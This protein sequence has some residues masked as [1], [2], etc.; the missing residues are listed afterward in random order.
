[1]DNLD[2]LI[3]LLNSQDLEKQHR[4]KKK[5]EKHAETHP[6]SE[7][8][9]DVQ[10]HLEDLPD[11]NEVYSKRLEKMDRKNESKQEHLKKKK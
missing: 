7:E 4:K 8:P 2:N 10:T 9:L 3:D 1:M 6:L 5:E 11:F